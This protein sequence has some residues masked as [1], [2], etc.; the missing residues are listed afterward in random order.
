MVFFFYPFLFFLFPVFIR[1]AFQLSPWISTGTKVLITTFGKRSY[2]PKNT[3]HSISHLARSTTMFPRRDP[4]NTDKTS[5][6]IHR[7]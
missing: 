7:K 2:G 1:P 3:E 6:A 4:S 5:D